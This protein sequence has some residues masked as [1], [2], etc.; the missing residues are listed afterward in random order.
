MSSLLDA[1]SV[2]MRLEIRS[3]FLTTWIPNGGY[4]VVKGGRSIPF[5]A[6]QPNLILVGKLRL[7]VGLYLLLTNIMWQSD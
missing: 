2:L 6:L 1:N 4:L 5:S 3:I 7:H